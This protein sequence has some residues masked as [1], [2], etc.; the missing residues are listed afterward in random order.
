LLVRVQRPLEDDALIDEAV[1]RVIGELSALGFDVEVLRRR[2]APS[3]L[4]RPGRLDPGTE[5]ALV[6]A[7]DGAVVLVSAWVTSGEHVFVQRFDTSQPG[8]GPD[9]IAVSSVE[10][11]RGMLIEPGARPPETAEATGESEEPAKVVEPEA[12]STAPATTP[13]DTTPTPLPTSFDAPAL[14]A[15]LFAAPNVGLEAQGRGTV[16]LG[17]SLTLGLGTFA[18]GAGLDRTLYTE[19]VRA[20][21][22]AAEFARTTGFATVRGQLGLSPAWD[23]FSHIALGVARYELQ[24]EADAGFLATDGG[25]TDFIVGAGAGVA[26]WPLANLGWFVALDG[27]VLPTP[28]AVRMEQREV[29]K[30]GAP[31]AVFSLGVA[32]R[33]R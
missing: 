17:A 15:T 18:V 32:A 14:S 1:N 3:E 6:F 11:L 31:A 28:I 8:N 10:A 27:W 24:A 16:G 26:H 19:V 33:V 29:A 21:G 9:V 12:A 25:H 4:D 7:R 2:T 30:L 23:G 5:G 13:R 22:G 20:E